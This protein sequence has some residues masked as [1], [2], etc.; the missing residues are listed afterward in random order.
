MYQIVQVA[1]PTHSLSRGAAFLRTIQSYKS[2]RSVF[3]VITNFATFQ[4]LQEQHFP[5]TSTLLLYIG[6]L[7]NIQIDIKLG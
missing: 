3:S 2:P 1:E 5:L 4:L 6:L 7:Y